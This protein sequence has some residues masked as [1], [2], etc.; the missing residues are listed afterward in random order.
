MIR[1]RATANC[2]SGERAQRRSGS[3]RPALPNAGS[4]RLLLRGARALP[5]RC[6]GDTAP[7]SAFRP[8]RRHSSIQERFCANC[9][10]SV[11]EQR[12]RSTIPPKGETWPARGLVRPERTGCAVKQ[13]TLNEGRREQHASRRL[14]GVAVNGRS[15]VTR[16]PAHAGEQSSNPRLS[17]ALGEEAAAGHRHAA[18]HE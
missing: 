18:D 4:G 6:A 13:N 2:A 11:A 9:A 7:E 1:A 10:C 8:S 14:R 17:V 5:F 16:E 12:W 15:Q 3:R